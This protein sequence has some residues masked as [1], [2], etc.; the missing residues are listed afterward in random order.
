[1]NT[2]NIVIVDANK[3]QHQ[4]GVQAATW[5]AAING[6]KSSVGLDVDSSTDSSLLIVQ[7]TGKLDVVVP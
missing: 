6:A 1:M 5:Q 7:Y 4:L 2:Y 3:V